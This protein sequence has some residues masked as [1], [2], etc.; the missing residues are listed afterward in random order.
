[1]TFVFILVGCQTQ[2]KVVNPSA[3]NAAKQAAATKEVFDIKAGKEMVQISSQ[4]VHGG[5]MY[6]LTNNGIAPESNDIKKKVIT[7]EINGKQ[8]PLRL[9]DI[10]PSQC[11]EIRYTDSV[12]D[13]YRTWVDILACPYY[14]GLVSNK[15]LLMINKS[16]QGTEKF[17]GATLYKTIP[18][19]KNK[20][21]QSYHDLNLSDSEI[22]DLERFISKTKIMILEDDC[23]NEGSFSK[24]KYSQIAAYNLAARHFSTHKM[25]DSPLNNIFL[26]ALFITSDADMKSDT[27]SQKLKVLLDQ[28]KNEMNEMLQE[29]SIE[30]TCQFYTNQTN[31]DMHAFLSTL[32]LNKSTSEIQDKGLFEVINSLESRDVC[33]YEL[34][35]EKMESHLK[36][37]NINLSDVSKDSLIGTMFYYYGIKSNLDMNKIGRASWCENIRTTNELLRP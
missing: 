20:S 28:Y 23:C 25:C 27:H 17:Y 10:T 1:M 2:E 29:S 5:Y 9:K 24:N 14:E 12:V 35:D 22:Q 31:D 16:I 3:S 37:H 26:T 15:G 32:S 11:S 18:N 7:V 21:I 33:G 13:N 36:A 34:S 8:E 6:T 4:E 19:Y 30:S